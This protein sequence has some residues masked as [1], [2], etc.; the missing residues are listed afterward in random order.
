MNPNGWFPND[1]SGRPNKPFG[2][3]VRSIVQMV[4]VHVGNS[5]CDSDFNTAGA[6]VVSHMGID[7]VFFGDKDC[8]F[9]T[10]RL[11]LLVSLWRTKKSHFRPSENKVCHNVD[12]KNI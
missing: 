10:M 3:S 1:D 8:K 11:G 4:V 9:T 6:N 2:T 7:I 12:K 5:A